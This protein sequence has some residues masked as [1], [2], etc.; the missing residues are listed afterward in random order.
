MFVVR[1]L[2]FIFL[3]SD[4]DSGSSS[5]SEPDAAK[6]SVPANAVEV[7]FFLYKSNEFCYFR[8]SMLVEILWLP[9]SLSLSLSN[10]SYYM[11]SFC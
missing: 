2:I 7:Y 1:N 4:S 10:V 5:G 9:P 6:A 8:G 3:F 11:F